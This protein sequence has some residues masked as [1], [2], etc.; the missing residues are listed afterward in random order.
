MKEAHILDER[1]RAR[2]GRSSAIGITA[3]STVDVARPARKT[4]SG[5]TTSPPPKR[6]ALDPA[7]SRTLSTLWWRTAPPRS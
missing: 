2:R 4:A 7:A 5:L 6:G 3:P 1:P